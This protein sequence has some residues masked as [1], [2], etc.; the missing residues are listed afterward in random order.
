MENN[1]TLLTTNTNIPA[2]L[3]TIDKALNSMSHITG[4][5]YVTGGNIGGFSKN[6]K[7][8]TDLN[9][10]IKMAASI[11][12]RDKAYNDAAQILQLPQYPQFKV[13][14]NHKDE[15]L[16]DIQLR[17]AIITNDDKIKKLQEFKDKATQ[18]LSEEDQKAILFKEMGDFLNTLKS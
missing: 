13:N 8:E 18:F 4:S 5:D 14:G 11:I 16:K 3:E 6:L 7:E 15:W 9:V 1:T 2:V 12:S 17:I 10:L